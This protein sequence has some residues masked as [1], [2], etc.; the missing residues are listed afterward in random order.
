MWPIMT[1]LMSTTAPSTATSN[2]S[3]ASSAPQPR[4]SMQSR[5]SMASDTA[6]TSSEE[7]DLTL[8]WSGRWTLGYRIFALN[9]LTLLL[10]AL[11][12]LYLDV[13]RSRLNKER[14]RQTR[15]E[16]ATAAAALTHVAQA[17]WP[18]LLATMSKTTGDRFRLYAA[19]GTL[20]ID[21]W[22]VTGPTYE[23]R[24]PN[25]Q[26]WTKD[27]ARALDRGFN[28]LVGAPTLDQFVEPP[29]DRLQAWPEALAARAKGKPATAVRNAPDL[30]PVIS[31]AVPFGKQVLLATENDRAFTRTVRSQR[32][33]ITG[34]MA[35][36]IILSVLLSLFL[37]R[38]IV[39]PMRRLAIA[40]H[41]VRLGRSRE[42][43]VPR[44]PSRSDEIG[45]LARAVSDMS[46]SLAH[47]IDNMEAFAADVTH[48]L[49]NPLASLR[50]AINALDRVENPELRHKLMA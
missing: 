36:L 42:V 33:N 38:T 27:V 26:A 50:S 13:F 7:A 21:S 44:L 4:T 31:A 40:A 49:K 5:P 12:T 24:D 47:R 41:R 25:T 48:E 19:D 18:A 2:V 30:T 16:T 8:S 10:V 35:F 39:R 37:A 17:E 28:A 9:I 11:S 6:S 1:T 22:K 32:A 29:V 46:Q 14:T 15:I 34:A 45:L 3:A 23:L 43:R 20:M